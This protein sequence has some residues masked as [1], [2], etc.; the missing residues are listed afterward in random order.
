MEPFPHKLMV[1]F[2]GVTFAENI[3]AFFEI[4]EDN[5]HLPPILGRDLEDVL[6]G[7][8]YYADFDDPNPDDS[9]PVYAQD[10]NYVGKVFCPV[11]KKIS[12]AI[13]NN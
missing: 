5:V 10:H 4:N 12:E 9:F 2:R 8:G 3:H 7:D 6:I 11:F 13:K 1:T